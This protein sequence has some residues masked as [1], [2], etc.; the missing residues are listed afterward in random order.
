MTGRP[1]DG[2]PERRPAFEP[3]AA[4]ACEESERG[5]EDAGECADHFGGTLEMRIGEGGAGDE[6]SDG[7]ADA[8]DHAGEEE[9]ARGSMP[10]VI[11]AANPRAWA[12]IP[13][14]AKMPMVFPMRS[15][16]KNEAGDGGDGG[17]LDAG[18]DEAEEE[19]EVD[20]NFPLVFEIAESGM[21]V[22]SE[23]IDGGVRRRRGSGA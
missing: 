12:S 3:E 13:K 9:G 18:V 16:A 6:E 23:A 15:E 2:Q 21:G 11:A 22:V 19:A 7:E 10:A 17:E 5:D 8:G 20:D 4:T 1:T 14:P